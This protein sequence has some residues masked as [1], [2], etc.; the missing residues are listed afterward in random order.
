M[1]SVKLKTYSGVLRGRTSRTMC[2]NVL[3]VSGAVLQIK[4]LHIYI[5]FIH[6]DY[7]FV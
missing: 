4:H 5:K 6:T 2:S 7:A 3:S 1:C